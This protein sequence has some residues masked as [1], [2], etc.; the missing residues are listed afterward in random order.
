MFLHLVKAFDCVPRETLWKVLHKFGVPAKVFRLKQALHAKVNV[1]FTVSGVTHTLDCA[2]GVKQGDIL[3]PALF[4]LY[5][6]AIMTT[7]CSSNIRPL[8]LFRTKMD[9]ILTGRRF[10]ARGEDFCLL[11]TSPSPRD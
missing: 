5:I 2:I 3:G 8:C 11:Y 9:D 7:W 1:E 6:A 10:T 4:T